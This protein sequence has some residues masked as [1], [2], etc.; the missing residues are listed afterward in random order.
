MGGLQTI[1]MGRVTAKTVEMVDEMVMVMMMRVVVVVV[2]VVLM[3][4]LV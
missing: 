3:L 4:I 1:A 2:D